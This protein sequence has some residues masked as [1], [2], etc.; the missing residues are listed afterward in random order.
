MTMQP[1]GL[2]DYYNMTM[3][4]HGHSDGLLSIGTSDNSVM[5]TL[6]LLTKQGTTK[7]C[8][9]YRI[10]IKSIIFIYI[11]TNDHSLK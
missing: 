3:L 7:N 4:R 5:A 1:S 11:I 9:I 6:F 8:T 2:V 10:K